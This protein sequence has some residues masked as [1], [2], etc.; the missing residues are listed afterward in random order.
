MENQ[1]KRRQGGDRYKTPMTRKTDRERFW[2]KVNKNGPVPANRPELGPCWL[3]L[4]CLGKPSKGGANGYGRF[5]LATDSGP[6]RQVQAHTYAYTLLKGPI[7]KG[8][9]PDHLC[10]NR[11]CVNPDH[12]EPVTRREN[13]RRGENPQAKN[14]K[15]THCNN[16]HPLSGDNL[17]MEGNSRRCK[18]CARAAYKR[19]EETHV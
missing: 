9:E 3:W 16:G 6:Y 2:A 18:A 5:Y 15:K 13:V 7:P 14:A 17:R 10:R 1:R 4:G 8:L 19:W 12:L 11:P